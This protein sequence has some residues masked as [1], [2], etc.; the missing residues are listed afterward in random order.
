M[1][2]GVFM[3]DGSLDLKNINV[4]LDGAAAAGFRLASV[5]DAGVFLDLLRQV[6]LELGGSSSAFSITCPH[7]RMTTGS[8][9][10][11][12]VHAA[13]A[14]LALMQCTAPTSCLALRRL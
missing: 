2:L 7:A 8:A 6:Q 5:E 4:M 3:P 9:K 10:P 11:G 14:G 1:A 12:L 13:H